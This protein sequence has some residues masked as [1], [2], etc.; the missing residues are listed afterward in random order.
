MITR[1]DPLVNDQ[2]Y[3][4][5]NKSIE[6]FKIFNYAND[7]HRMLELINYYKYRDTPVKFSQFSTLNKIEQKDIRQRFAKSDNTLVNIIAFCLMPTHIHLVLK[8]TSEKGIS[9]FTGNILNSYAKYFNTKYKRKGPLWEG[10][11]KSVLIDSDRQLL[12]LTRYLHLNPVSAGLVNRPDKW[13]FSSYKEYIFPKSN[14]EI[15]KFDDILD[16]KQG[17]YK[18]FV[19]NRISYQRELTKIKKL[20]AE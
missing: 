16:I 9:T 7:F 12:H 4:V 13:T 6:G 14:Y 8:Q 3:H 19:E 18:K 10:R 5:L 11:F 15:C 20:L 2:I 17:H 1:K